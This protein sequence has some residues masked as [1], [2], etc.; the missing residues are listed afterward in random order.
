MLLINVFIKKLMKK[1]KIPIIFVQFQVYFFS[2]W[3]LIK[4]TYKCLPVYI[5]IIITFL[6]PT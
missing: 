3:D 4:H 1:V 5:N 6:I 2:N